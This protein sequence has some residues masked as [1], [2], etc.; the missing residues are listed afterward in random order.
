MFI[1][2][3]VSKNSVDVA[4]ACETIKLQGVN[5]L[6]VAEVL[7]E[8][9]VELVVVEATGGY[10]RPVVESLQDAGVP[11][12]IINPRQGR[13]F[14]RALGR[15]AKT[16]R[17]DAFVLAQFAKLCRPAAAAPVIAELKRL[18]ALV[19][20]RRQ[21][22]Q[23]LTAEKNRLHQAVEP[24]VRASLKKVADVLQKTLKET[25]AVITGLL[26]QNE[27]WKKRLAV[28]Q[29]VKGVG[30]VTAATLIAEMPELGRIGRKQVAALAGV[31]PF[32]R[33][34]GKWKGKSFCSGGRKSVR[35]A[36]YM[37]T[38]TA[39]RRHEPLK[40]FYQKLVLTGKPKK[41]AL[42]AAMRRLLVILNAMARDSLKTA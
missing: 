24:E 42:N 29:S 25:T 21:L 28:L 33:Q 15:V 9:A 16:D 4:S 12:A 39:V 18:Q 1:G 7:R 34:S 8:Y 40:I 31:A 32:D 2:I 10:E 3:D 27:D 26:R 23:T 37:A 6:R 5:P 19:A 22:Q 36:L 11:V 35:T 14:A 38:L 30:P 41:L 17:I 20:H 13:D